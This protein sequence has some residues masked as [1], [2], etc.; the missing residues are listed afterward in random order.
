MMPFDEERIERFTKSTLEDFEKGFLLDDVLFSSNISEDETDGTFTKIGVR[1]LVKRELFLPQTG[2]VFIIPEMVGLGH[3]IT[4]GEKKYFVNQIL[5][6][7]AIKNIRIRKQDFNPSSL[8]TELNKL[9][10]DIKEGLIF[11]NALNKGELQKKSDWK[12]SFSYSDG[13]SFE[14]NHPIHTFGGDLLKDK[15]IIFDKN[16]SNWIRVLF[17]NKYFKSDIKLNISMGSGRNDLEVDV[18]VYS[19]IKLYIHDPS[20]IKIIELI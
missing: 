3:S 12:F 18:L 15:I 11:I 1:P 16:S 6:N 7:N 4:L 14:L 5:S 19:L 2:S 9:N 13:E 20:S 17:R 10:S 8:R